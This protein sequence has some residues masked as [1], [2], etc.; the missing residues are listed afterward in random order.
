MMYKALRVLLLT[1]LLPASLAPAHARVYLVSVGVADYPGTQNDLTL[2]ARD[3]YTIDSIY[4]KNSNVTSRRLQNRQATRENILSAMRTTYAAAGEND[5]VVLFF[6]G[7]GYRG[8]FVAYDGKM[9]YTEVRQAMAASRCRNKMIFAD[10]CF[11]GKIRT[12][13]REARNSMQA[14]RK[15][16]VMLFL[17][18]RSDETSIENR[19]MEN[20]FFT[21]F[22]Q[23]GL[24]GG[25]D[26]DRDRVITARELYDY[27]HDG[28]VK[29][30]NGKQHPVMWGRFSDDMP[31]MK[32]PKKK[33]KH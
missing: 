25:A 2:P 29:L 19:R 18:S 24:R 20:G 22:L 4:A 3:A 6:S 32:W 12:D 31:V 15:A 26:A 7:H 21:T 9:S 23:R 11:S 28:V 16:R 30:S 17:S 13:R 33:K 5:I 27:V 1:L 8:G 10:A 14:A